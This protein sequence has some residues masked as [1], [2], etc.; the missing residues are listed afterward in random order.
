MAITVVEQVRGATA[1]E[2]GRHTFAA[3]RVEHRRD[4]RRPGACAAIAASVGTAIARRPVPNARPFTSRPRSADPVN[5][6]GRSKPRIHRPRRAPRSHRAAARRSRATSLG[7]G[8]LGSAARSPISASA[9]QSATLGAAVA[10]STASS[11]GIR[12]HVFESQSIARPLAR[13]VVPE[14]EPHQESSTVSPSCCTNLAPC[15]ATGARRA[16]S[17]A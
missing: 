6:P 9:R 5:D 1:L 12:V 16:P 17:T 2:A 14:R 8:T 11:S 4:G 15:A 13:E 3:P 10:V 7:R